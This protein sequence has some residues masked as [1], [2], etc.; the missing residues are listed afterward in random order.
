MPRR[1]ALVTG[2]RSGIGAAIVAALKRDGVDVQVLDLADGFD[3]SDPH[4]WESVDAVDLANYLAREKQ[5]V[6]AN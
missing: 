2:G 6:E 5:P 4:A 3:V 1:N